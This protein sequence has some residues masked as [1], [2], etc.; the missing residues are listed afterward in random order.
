SRDRLKFAD[1]PRHVLKRIVVELQVLVFRPRSSPIEQV[2]VIAFIEHELDEAVAG[3]KIEDVR[4]IHQR[5]YHQQGNRVA[6]L[7]RYD[8]NIV[9]EL[10]FIECPHQFF[11]GLS[12]GGSRRHCFVKRGQFS[13]QI[14]KRV[15]DNR[16]VFYCYF[17]PLVFRLFWRLGC[18]GIGFRLLSVAGFVYFSIR[19]SLASMSSSRISILVTRSASATKSARDGMLNCSS[20][21][22]IAFSTASRNGEDAE[23]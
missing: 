20:T 1:R 11:R 3:S 18:A 2:Q 10:C 7:F 5:E 8:R 14:G 16:C 6:L 4:P 13:Y 22:N 17:A 19:S 23:R 9:I 12:N 21:R 15:S